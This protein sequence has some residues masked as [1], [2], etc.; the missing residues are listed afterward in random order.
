MLPWQQ[1][2]NGKHFS[3]SDITTYDNGIGFL[4]IDI[5]QIHV[6]DLTYPEV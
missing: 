1:V 4:L 5:W 6:Y 3:K 2:C